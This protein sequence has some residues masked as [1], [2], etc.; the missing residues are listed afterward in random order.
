MNEERFDRMMKAYCDPETEAFSYRE[1]TS[2]RIGIKSMIAALVLVMISA[3]MIPAFFSNRHSFVLEVSAA[4]N[5]L[6]D[7]ASGKVYSEITMYDMNGNFLDRYYTME[8]E[9]LID[10]DDIEDV[11]FRSLNGF[12]RFCVWYDSDS[13]NIGDDW[14]MWY[15]SGG[16]EDPFYL[17]RPDKFG[18][19]EYYAKSDL[20]HT[21]DWSKQYR[22]HI[23]YVATGDDGYFLQPEDICGERDD[24]IEITVTFSDGDILTKRLSVTYPDGVMAVH[25]ID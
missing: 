1:R 5:R 15:D 21:A 8:A 22:Y 4:E 12:G 24:I 23:S 7:S 9:M 10:G 17:G 20:D 19:S 2:R 16:E 6:L 11:S 25:E 3:M 18:L 14:G 13:E